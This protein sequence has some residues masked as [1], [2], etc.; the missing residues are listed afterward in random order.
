MKKFFSIL[1]LVIAL[2]LVANPVIAAT[3]TYQAGESSPS[4]VIAGRANLWGAPGYW[5]LTNNPN[6]PD[7]AII[8]GIYEYWTSQYPNTG[9]QVA[10][11]RSST[12]SGYYTTSGADIPGFAGMPVKQ[13]WETRCNAQVSTWIWPVLTIRW[14][15]PDSANG[16]IEGVTTLSQDESTTETTIWST[17]ASDD[18]VLTL[19]E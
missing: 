3:G 5:D 2:L 8:T 18:F 9:L 4:V 12:G 14:S 6:I 19:D 1:T 15:T 17:K 13:K 11:F 10:L 7:G 16:V